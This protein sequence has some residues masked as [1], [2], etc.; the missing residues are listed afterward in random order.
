[1][2]RHP[3]AAEGRRPRVAIIGGGMTGLGAARKLESL[4]AAGASFDWVLYERDDHFGGKVQTVRRDGYVIEGGP[5]S[6]IIEKPWPITTA[7]ELGIEDRLLNSNEEIRKSY[8]Y[9]GGRIHELP[10]GIVLMIPTRL[11]P[12]ALSS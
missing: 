3:Q 8:V 2:A 4:R 10:E 5:D 11:V 9:S 7:R 1:M 6:A 12:F